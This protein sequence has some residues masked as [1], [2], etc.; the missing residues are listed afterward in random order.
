MRQTT[1][2]LLVWAYCYFSSFPSS[3][4]LAQTMPQSWY[5]L[6]EDGW[7][8]RN[9][10]FAW[11][12]PSKEFEEKVVELIKTQGG[13]FDYFLR[14]SRMDKKLNSNWSLHSIRSQLALSDRKS[15]RLNSSHSQQSRMPS[16]A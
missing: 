15:T 13:S 2:I 6:P 4:L 8:Q 1:K 5:R 11:E 14:E 3:S 10:S 12:H 16:S 9:T 7:V